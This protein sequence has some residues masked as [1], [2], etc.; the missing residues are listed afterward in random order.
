[1]KSL[2]QRFADSPPIWLSQVTARLDPDICSKHNVDKGWTAAQASAALIFLSFLPHAAGSAAKISDPAI[3]NT[4][5][6]CIKKQFPPNRMG[7]IAIKMHQT[8]PAWHAPGTLFPPHKCFSYCP[9]VPL[10]NGVDACETER[11]TRGPRV[12]YSLLF[13]RGE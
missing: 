10:Q 2:I 5:H 8:H 9:F 6:I 4:W 12:H 11:D 3:R 7:Y 13:S 1:M